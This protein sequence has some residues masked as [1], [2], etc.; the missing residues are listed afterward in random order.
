SHYIEEADALCGL[1]AIM[2]LGRIVALGSPS[3]LKARVHADYIEIETN[4]TIDEA[5][6][7]S[8]SGVQEVRTQGATWI[9]KVTRAEEVLPR[10]FD[11]LK[12]DLIRR[13]NVEKPSLESV[14]IDLT[15]KRIDQAGSEVHDYRKFYANVRR[16]R[17]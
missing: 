10:L 13:I 16:A 9:L 1:V 17:G 7:H 14:F 8:V 3:D 5:R 15:G 6:L 11:T 12:P 2:D 4:E